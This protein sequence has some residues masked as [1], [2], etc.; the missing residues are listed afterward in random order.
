MR[1]WLFATDNQVRSIWF[2]NSCNASMRPWLFATDNF[3]QPPIKDNDMPSF[4]EAVAIC[5]G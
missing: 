1:P 3:T 2:F 5:H 4:N